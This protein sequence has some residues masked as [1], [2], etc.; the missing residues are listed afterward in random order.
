MNKITRRSFLAFV[1]LLPSTVRATVSHQQASREQHESTFDQQWILLINAV[2]GPCQSV[3]MVGAS[4]KKPPAPTW[5]SPWSSQLLGS[6]SRLASTPNRKSIYSLRKNYQL[7]VR[8]DF[9]YERTVRVNGYILSQTEV[10]IFHLINAMANTSIHP[11]P[12][13]V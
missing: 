3:V 6:L 8:K 10:E 2:I 12:S 5:P 4:C 9:M 13:H 11:K 7:R 1:S